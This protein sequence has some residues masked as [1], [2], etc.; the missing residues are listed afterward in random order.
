AEKRK[1]AEATKVAEAEKR[2]AAE[3]TKVAEA[4]KRKAAEAAKA[5]ES[6]KQRFLERF[7]VL[8]EEKKAALRAAEMERKKITNIMKN[9]GVRSSDSV[10]LVEGNRS[11]TESSCRNRFRFSCS[12]M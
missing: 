7:S 9:K 10:P 4:E 3:A 2:K 5:V 12:V 6:Q 1:A 11:V 8:E